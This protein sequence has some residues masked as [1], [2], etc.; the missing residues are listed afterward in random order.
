MK[1]EDPEYFS[2]VLQTAK[3]ET[4]VRKKSSAL[5]RPPLNKKRENEIA[6][7]QPE[8]INFSIQ[9]QGLELSRAL[10]DNNDTTPHPS[11]PEEI[12]VL[13]QEE[14]IESDPAKFSRK[15]PFD[16][17]RNSLKALASNQNFQVSKFCQ[18]SNDSSTEKTDLQNPVTDTKNSKVIIRNLEES[19]D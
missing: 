10:A 16:L 4:G 12:T 1:S 15:S 9:T 6:V 14:D 3:P 2:E 18:S 19:T 8:E 17:P 11:L 13:S 7:R 5:L